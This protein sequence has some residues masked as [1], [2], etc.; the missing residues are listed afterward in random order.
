MFRLK[1]RILNRIEICVNN[2]MLSIINFILFFLN[3]VVI[4]NVVKNHL[5]K[6]FLKQITWSVNSFEGFWKLSGNRGK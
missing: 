6:S 5:K 4:K 3:I 2:E 1:G